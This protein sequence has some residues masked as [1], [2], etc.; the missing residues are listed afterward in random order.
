MTQ[1]IVGRVTT[2]TLQRVNTAATTVIPSGVQSVSIT[3][4]AS[5]GGTSPTVQGCPLP[6][7][8]TISLSANPEQTLSPVTV[9]TATGDDV[10]IAVIQ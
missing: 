7:N 6:A 3:V 8:V 10:I 2:P 9:V 4:V 5:S 1:Q